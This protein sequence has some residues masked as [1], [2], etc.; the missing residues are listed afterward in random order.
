MKLSHPLRCILVAAGLMLVAAA[1]AQSDK[2]ISVVVAYPAG[3]QAD[4]TGRIVLPTMQKV[5]GPPLVVDNVSGAAGSIGSQKVHDAKPDGQTI[6]VATPIELVQT[7]MAMRT[8]YVSEDFRLV[9]QIASTYMMLVTRPDL[10]VSNLSEV[11]ALAK[12]SEGKELSY[13]TTGR[14]TIYHLVAERFARDT[15]VK[16]LHVPYKGAAQIFSDLAGG[17]IDMVFMPLGG[18]VAGMIQTGKFKAIAYTG[19]TRHPSFP[20]VPTMNETKLV[21]DFVFDVWAGVVVPKNTPDATVERLSSALNEALRQDNVRKELAASGAIP[22]SPM[23][24]AD[25]QKFY[26]AEIT[27]YR[28]IGKAIN[29]QPE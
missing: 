14:G 10:P 24:A 2:P 4:V 9:G 6:M 21:Q 7:P 27:R 15:G 1:Q 3:G 20:N 22:S 8:K 26:S 23:S 16:L 18:P 12:K 17:Q 19:P 25:A 28:A 11:I 29:L 13:G 5:L